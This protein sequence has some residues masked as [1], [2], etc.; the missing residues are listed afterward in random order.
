MVCPRERDRI[1]NSVGQPWNHGYIFGNCHH[2]S[3]ANGVG[4]W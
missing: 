3:C 2:W 4:V 1:R